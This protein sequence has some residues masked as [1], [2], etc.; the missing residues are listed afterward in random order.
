MNII[1]FIH[2]NFV[3]KR[4]VKVLSKA[5]ADLIPPDCRILDVG[6]GD[7]LID[8]MIMDIRKDAQI[9]GIDVLVR[10]HTFIEVKKFDGSKI[11][12]SDNSF[13]CVMFVDVLHH[14]TEP[15]SLLKEAARV[16]KKWLIIKDHIKKNRM[17]E[18]ILKF[19]DWVGNA[20]HGVALPYNYMTEEEWQD[21]FDRIETSVKRFCPSVKL[22][23]FPASLIFNRNLHFIALLEKTV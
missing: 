13:D 1:D 11:P 12:Y 7:G 15:A 22:Y 18:K 6:C 21:L 8:K 19:M 20:R 3:F 5:I 14:T 10:P 16:S 9:E 23:P 4:R 2:Q 17:D